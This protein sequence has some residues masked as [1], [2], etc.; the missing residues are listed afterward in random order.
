METVKAE[1]RVDAGL[2]LLCA[3]YYSDIRASADA[4][5]AEIRSGDHG[6]GEEAREAF[7]DLMWQGV[8]GDSW[9]IYTFR[10]QIACLVSDNSGYS[11]EEF[12]SD[13]I[14]EDGE[15]RW[16]WLAFGAVYADTLEALGAI[17]DFDVNDPNPDPE[18]S[19]V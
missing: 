1:D 17:D 3:E 2:R 7:H 12:G 18:D 11:V 16:G 5:V 6:T 9:V 15:I 8:D 19:D 10:A 13:G 14:V 4:L